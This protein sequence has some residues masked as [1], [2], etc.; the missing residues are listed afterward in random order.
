MPQ[1]R[2]HKYLSQWLKDNKI[3][4]Y[5]APEIKKNIT[6]FGV[7]VNGKLVNNQLEWVYDN[8]KL[9][10]NNWTV[11]ELGDTTKI[12][13]IY[14]DADCLVLKKPFGLIVEAGAGHPFDNVAQW[15]WDNYPEQKFQTYYQNTEL[16]ASGLVHRL[17]KDT[18]GVL[19]IAKTPAK[20]KFLQDQFRSRS[21]IKKYLA[22]VDGNFDKTIHI[23]NW[24]SRDKATS[25]RQKFFWSED[26]AMDFS[27][28]SRM[29]KSIMIPKVY[30]PETNQTLIQIQIKTGRMHQIR[31]QCEALGFPISNCK[32]YNNQ[33]IFDA[34]KI[35]KNPENQIIIPFEPLQTMTKN[36]F[37]NM[38]IKFFG[39]TDYCLLS[40][41]LE[42]MLP[43][44]KLTKF[45]IQ[46]V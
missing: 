31:V 34:K 38:Q 26:E 42:I 4:G 19:L 1:I 7:F 20:H 6:N 25:I 37:E 15:L 5:T 11:R 2:L 35:L 40:N 18:T 46:E 22:V 44:Q 17:D 29:A 33:N 8:Q 13:I 39:N 23:Q 28:D 14:E 41:E 16:P 32:T 24:Q 36:G 30:C 45:V 43:S 10:L 12:E 21:V 9:E 3:Y 27:V